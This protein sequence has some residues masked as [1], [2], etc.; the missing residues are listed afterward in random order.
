MSKQ[1]QNYI[2]FLIVCLI[3]SNMCLAQEGCTDPLAYNCADSMVGEYIN[4]VGLITYDYSCD[5]NPDHAGPDDGPYYEDCS[6]EE[7][8]E[9]Y[10]DPAAETDDDSCR[11]PHAPHGAE[12]VFNV[13]STAINVDW[14][15]FIPP[16][17]AI[18]ESYHVQKCVGESC[19]W[20][21]GFTQGDTNLSTSFE[22]VYVD[23]LVI[24]YVIAVKYSNNPY[25]GWAIGDSYIC[26]NS[27]DL[28]GD[29]G[30]NVLDV[31][32]LVNCVLGDFCSD[33]CAGDMNG[34]GGYNVL[35]IVALANC[36]LAINCG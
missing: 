22:D 11:Y 13:T 34:D 21:A 24:K 29:G 36:V 33:S 18:L 8:C 2:N 30:Y 12:V 15:A 31:V 28:N 3:A 1:I 7:I 27:G 10:Y 35:D 4:E 32:A 9:G 5:G 6:A 25:W 14:S 17:S 16:A 23:D 20:I 19:T 26:P